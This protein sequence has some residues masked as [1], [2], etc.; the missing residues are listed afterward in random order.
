MPPIHSADHAADDASDHAAFHSAHHAAFHRTIVIVAA[1]DVGDLR[2]VTGNLRGLA[3]LLTRRLLLGVSTFGLVEPLLWD[4]AGGGGGGGGG[5]EATM[6]ADI[7]FSIT[8][9]FSLT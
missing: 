9:G 5:A 8:S 3:E 7:G 4:A 2:N 1:W 6:K